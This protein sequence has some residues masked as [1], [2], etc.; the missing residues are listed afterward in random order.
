MAAS[1]WYLLM[2]ETTE[3]S[4]E[5]LR[6]TKA[7]MM[8]LLSSLASKSRP[9]SVITKGVIGGWKS[10]AKKVTSLV[11]QHRWFTNVRAWRLDSRDTRYGN[12][13]LQ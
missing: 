7:V 6:R 5:S 2:K 12:T 13:G 3:G 11:D 10:I 9:P 4:P 1:S 8:L